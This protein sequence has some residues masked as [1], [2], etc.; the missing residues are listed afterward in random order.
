MAN[1]NKIKL[2]SIDNQPIFL[3]K[4]KW[5]CD[6][7]WGF[8]YIGNSRQHFHIDSLIK[9]VT[10]VN[11]IFDKTKITQKEWWVIRDLFIQAYALKNVAEVYY[12]G[13]HQLTVEGLTDILHSADKA[14]Q[15]NKDLELILDK[16]WDYICKAVNKKS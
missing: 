10:N 6:W 11:K 14:R 4:H 12:H 15:I 16:V 8:G 2:G 7:Y 9:D 1:L 13:G 3:T 5:D